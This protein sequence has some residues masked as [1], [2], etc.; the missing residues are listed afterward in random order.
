MDE[1]ARSSIYAQDQTDPPRWPALAGERRAV[2]AIIGGGLT[3][4]STAAHLAETGQDVVLLEAH[5]PG[6]GA[7]GR[8]GGQ[9]NPGLKYDPSQIIAK[10]G[11][12]AGGK[13]VAFAWSTVQQTAHL[14]DR[15]GIDCDLRLNGTLRAAASI[16]DVS[17]VQASQQDMAGHGMPV[18]WLDAATMAGMTGHRRYHGGFIDRRGGDLNPL[19]FCHGLANA[20]EAAGA[21]IH[22][23][24]RALS[25]VRDGSRWRVATAGGALI[26]DKVLVCCNGYADGLV[27]GLKRAMV[28]VFSSVLATP[29]LPPPLAA[30]IMP[31][32][33]V[34]YESGLVTVYYRVDAKNRLILGGRGPMHPI[35]SPARLRPI[36]DHAHRLWP[37]LAQLGWQAAWNGRVAVTTDHMPHLHELGEGLMT[38]YGYNG[39]GVALATAMGVALAARLS[40]QSEAADLPIPLSPLEPIRF[41]AFWP[42]G[43]HATIAWSRL[44]A[45]RYAHKMDRR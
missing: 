26:A 21:V 14:I 4:L 25:L 29:P 5:Q 35:A 8:N 28:P 6:W 31:G 34:L 32:R 15:L 12:E 3:G 30:R 11:S 36:E 18:D 43:V 7:S 13:L 38:V 44:K 27:P 33:Q 40:G 9:L 22:G 45:C 16:A 39:R 41:H 37:D 42:V 1:T 23:D 20:A 24:S 10:L 2:I 19:R 17:A